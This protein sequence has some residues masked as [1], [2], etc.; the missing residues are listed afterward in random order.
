M[1]DRHRPRGR[2]GSRPR[3]AVLITRLVVAVDVLVLVLVG[4]L[5]LVLR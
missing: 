4:V 1:R 3:R 5:W 2:A